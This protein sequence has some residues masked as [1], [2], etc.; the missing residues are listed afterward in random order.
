ML[1]VSPYAKARFVDHTLASHTSM[2]AF[3]EHVFGLPP[4]NSEDASAY[5]YADAFDF[6]QQPIRPSPLP[7]HG[8]PL[9][10]LQQ[11]AAHPPDP[12]DPT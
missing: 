11:I 12:D 4:L 8:V 3:T 2:L 10:S 1:I 7:L 5:D 6:T 9:S